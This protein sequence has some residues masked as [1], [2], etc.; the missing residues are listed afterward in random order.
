MLNTYQLY[1]L[2]DLGMIKYPVHT[3]ITYVGML[4]PFEMQVADLLKLQPIRSQGF[5]AE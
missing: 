2:V 4:V 3:G 1:L 5:T